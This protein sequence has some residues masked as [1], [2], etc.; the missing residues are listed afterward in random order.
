MSHWRRQLYDLFCSP[1]LI[2]RGSQHFGDVILS[3]SAGI[4]LLFDLGKTEAP[5]GGRMKEAESRL[6]NQGEQL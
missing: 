5:E 1:G 2:S 6:W 3:P 4:V